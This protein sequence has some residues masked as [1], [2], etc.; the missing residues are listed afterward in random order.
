MDTD[1]LRTGIL[2]L[3]TDVHDM[4]AGI[5][6]YLSWSGVNPLGDVDGDGNVTTIDQFIVE[7]AMGT[8]PGAP[9]WELRADIFPATTTYP[10][11]ADNIINAND[12]SLVLANM[13]A[14]GQFYEH[15]VMAPMWEIIVEEVERCQDVVL[16]IAPWYFDGMEWYRYDEGAHFV[17]VA[18]LN[19]TTWEIVLS[20]PIN[21][22]AEAGGPGDVPIPHVHPTPEPPYVTH[23]NASLVSHDMYPVINEPCPG[24]PLA[25]VG[26]P[27][28]IANPQGTIWQ[29]EAAVITSPSAVDDVAV[30]NVVTLKDGC[31][32]IPTVSRG[33]NMEV[34]VTVENQGTDP[35][36]F[37]VTVYGNMTTNGNMTEIET[38]LVVNLPSGSQTT[39]I[40]TWNSTTLAYGNYTVV[41]YA[42]PLPSETDTADNTFTGGLIKVT[43]P[44]DIDGDYK[45]GPS[46]FTRLSIAYG[47]TP[48]KPGYIGSWNP[49]ADLDGSKKVGPFD[50]TLLSVNYYNHYP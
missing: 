43:I 44:G 34:N 16:L 33:Y 31:T 6:Q 11:V 20:D 29:I 39:L 48:W 19:A 45:I 42:W 15:T 49:N 32:P 18:G 21:D 1:G 7:A 8:V 10:P 5:T 38:Q 22:N 2:K 14:T 13:G 47:S 30:T 41:A 23:N 26:Y 3:G 4:E 36:T 40:F 17:T 37:N 28:S 25:L 50:F 46:D 24:G 27:G 35:A 9:G 12:L